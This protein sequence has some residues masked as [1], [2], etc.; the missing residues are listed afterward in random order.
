M[1]QECLEKLENAWMKSGTPIP[2]KE[3]IIICI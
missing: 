3:G 2:K 1:H